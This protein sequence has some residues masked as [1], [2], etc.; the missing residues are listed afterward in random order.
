MLC[1]ELSLGLHCPKGSPCIQ[2]GPW[3]TTVCW[4][5]AT[6]QLS[7]HTCC[8]EERREVPCSPFSGSHR[9]L[10]GET[11]QRAFAPLW[12]LPW[13]VGYRTEA[14]LLLLFCS[15]FTEPQAQSGIRSPFLNL[16]PHRVWGKKQK[17][18]KLHFGPGCS[19]N[20][21]LYLFKTARLM[22]YDAHYT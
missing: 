3:G 19:S 8:W 11:S 2:W 1:T 18:K 21:L 22:V 20:L 15:E 17:K 16:I 5:P 6:R 14:M 10:E 7:T 12:N 9:K 4:S 13:K